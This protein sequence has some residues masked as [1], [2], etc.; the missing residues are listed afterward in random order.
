MRI[1]F[2]QKGYALFQLKKIVE[3]FEMGY[4]TFV[5]FVF[6]VKNSFTLGKSKLSVPWFTLS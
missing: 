4:F 6:V 3:L 1:K 2:V 5:C